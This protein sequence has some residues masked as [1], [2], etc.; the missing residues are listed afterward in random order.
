MPRTRQYAR[1]YRRRLAL[2]A[3][4]G[5][6]TSQA[7]GHP[8]ADERAVLEIASEPHWRV[9]LAAAGP[10][11]LVTLDV[12]F[13]DAQRAGRYGQLSRQLSE[14]RISPRE[15]EARAKRLRPIAGVRLLADARAALALTF[16]SAS[17]DYIF[18]SGPV[19]R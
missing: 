4:R 13:K 5:L 18:E 12:G 15:F 19:G 9:T 2:A 6:T 8:R 17:E 14:G 16:V 10:P 11:R 1:E 7:R 3:Q